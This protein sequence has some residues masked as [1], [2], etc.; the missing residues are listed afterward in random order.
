MNKVFK[1]IWNHATQTWVAVSELGRAKGKTKSKKLATLTTAAT[2]VISAV[3]ASQGAHAAYSTA[4]SVINIS[5]D[6]RGAENTYSGAT[7]SVI[8]GYKNT[9][10][11]TRGSEGK[12]VYGANNTVGGNAGL[13]VGNQNS[14]SGGAATAVGAGNKANGAAATALG[15]NASATLHGTAVGDH[16]IAD[17]AAGYGTAVGNYVNATGY[18]ATAI[19]TNNTASETTSVAIGAGNKATATAA[20]AIGYNAT[21]NYAGAYAIGYEANAT[22]G[23]AYAYGAQSK[24]LGT[25]A[26]ALGKN[27]RAGVTEVRNAQGNVITEWVA[28]SVAIGTNSV[29]TGPSSFAAGSSA[30]ATGNSAIAMGRDSKTAGDHSIVIG[31]NATSRYNV[32][33]T[34]WNTENGGTDAIVIGRDSKGNQGTVAIGHNASVNSKFGIAIGENATN[35][36]TTS[37]AG[38]WHSAIEYAAYDNPDNMTYEGEEPNKGKYARDPNNNLNPRRGTGV[39]IGSNSQG[40]NFSNIVGDWN[41]GDQSSVIMGNYNNASKPSSIVLGNANKADGNFNIVMGRQASGKADGDIAIGTTARAGKANGTGGSVALGLAAEATG[42]QSIALGGLS[43]E[44][45]IANA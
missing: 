10:V 41:I 24:A 2:V 29:S 30:T 35:R 40:K 4:G 16:A 33:G 38:E 20:L 1:V 18:Q 9:V 13:A 28:N 8:V 42:N 34:E 44:G 5:P 14:A 22:G 36:V 17:N 25:N 7:N 26:L 3:A 12:I 43:N 32:P 23:D 45:G 31:T 6:A 39:V 21:A 15:N 19:G 37:G 11:E 27:S